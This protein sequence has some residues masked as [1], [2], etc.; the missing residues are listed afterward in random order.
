MT[1]SE[2]KQAVRKAGIRDEDEILTIEC[3]MRHGDGTLHAVAQGEF[4]RL[5]ERPSEAARRD[6]SDCAC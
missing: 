3:E 6:A 4:V 1:W 2:I 5:S